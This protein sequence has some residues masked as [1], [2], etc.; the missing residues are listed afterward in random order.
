MHR[1]LG[2]LLLAGVA[3][4]QTVEGA[5]TNAL[6]GAG[7]PGARVILIHNSQI[8][9]STTADAAGNFRFE[10]LAD[11]TY[12]LQ[13]SAEGYA[14]DL[15]HPPPVFQVAAGATPVQ[16]TGG[17]HPIGH[18]S[19]RVTDGRGDPVVKAQ[20][21]LAPGLLQAETD[22]KGNFELDSIFLP[23]RAT[24]TLS[25]IPP[26]GWK[27][28][29]PDPETGQPRR[30]AQTFYP[31]VSD[32]DAAARIPFLAGS[33]L[34]GM[35]LKLLALPVH[36]LRGIL[37]NPDG[38]PAS[39]L[40]VALELETAGPGVSD[41]AESKSDGAFE[42]PAV[43]D[44]H[45]RLTA[46]A[47]PADAPGPRA[48]AWI[49]MAGRD[50][51][52]IKLRLT[53][54]FSVTGRVIMETPQGTTPPR[55]PGV[56]LTQMHGEIVLHTFLPLFPNQQDGR[57]RIDG[58]YPG[59]YR[60]D[61]GLAPPPY[62]LDSIRLGD[63]PARQDVELSAASPPVTIV[64]RTNGGSV[65]GT[66]ENCGTA[67]VWLLSEEDPRRGVFGASCDPSGRFEIRALRPGEYYALV[68]PLYQ[69]EP[70]IDDP[71]FLQSATRVTVRAGETSQLDLSLSTLR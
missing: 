26:R 38:T 48:L 18:I 28:P 25:V 71:A 50:L 33:D 52:A 8:L 46:Q 19:G 57:F 58:V 65:R 53:P 43:T 7:I 20:V 15:Y 55:P 3:G 10:G 64:Y 61:P 1:L 30:W 39:K 22:E 54:P 12:M 36:A 29:A 62:Y 49:E 69:P 66:V 35:D 59:T 9:Y 13:Y 63:Q 40:P 56:G 41:R 16:L 6:T 14:P 60:V 17:L 24:Y 23:T 2:L 51:D 11:G 34:Q 32:P 27:P 45:W 68:I 21:Q 44:G 4:A 37:L 5:I 70:A 31:G 67:R 42:F 47:G